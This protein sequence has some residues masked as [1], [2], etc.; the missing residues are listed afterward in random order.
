MVLLYRNNV[1]AKFVTKYVDGTTEIRSN[2][3]GSIS[4]MYPE[5]PLCGQ[6]GD[7]EY[8]VSGTHIRQ[9][10]RTSGVILGGRQQ[11]SRDRTP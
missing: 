4:Q 8:V 9:T 10:Q 6:K 1:Y 3:C 5:E 2:S 11:T 7:D